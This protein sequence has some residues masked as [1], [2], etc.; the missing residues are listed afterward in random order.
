MGLQG[1]QID[2]SQVDGLMQ[3]ASTLAG[4]LVVL[5]IEGTSQCE[6]NEEQRDGIFTLRADVGMRIAGVLGSSIS[7]GSS[8][9]AIIGDALFEIRSLNW[10]AD[11]HLRASIGQWYR[12]YFEHDGERKPYHRDLGFT[13]TIS[14]IQG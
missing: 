14:F 10:D 13:L 1:S 4:G 9:N 8:G 7:E 11:G 12:K 3:Q 2:L 5:P 6:S